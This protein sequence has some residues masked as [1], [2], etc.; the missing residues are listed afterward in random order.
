MIGLERK[1]AAA[2]GLPR[3]KLQRVVEEIRE[4]IGFQAKEAEFTENTRKLIE[5]TEHY[6]QVST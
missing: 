4:E 6:K 1:Q 2:S 3:D 5:L